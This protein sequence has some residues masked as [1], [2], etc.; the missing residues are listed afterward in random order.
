MISPL[1]ERKE[2]LALLAWLDL[3]S[4]RAL[5][6]ETIEKLKSLSGLWAT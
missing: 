3:V 5:P 6:A 2:A 1:F 4:T